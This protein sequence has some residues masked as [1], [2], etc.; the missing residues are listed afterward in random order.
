MAV[1]ST[2]VLIIG[3][4]AAGLSTANSVLA[5]YPEKEVTVVRNV[6]YT[7]VPCGIPYIYGMLNLVEKDKIPDEGFAK[8]G[9]NFVIGN[10]IDINR[11]AKLAIF[12]D[13]N[14]IK[15][16]KL[17][18][19]VGSKPSLPPIDGLDLKNV[20]PVI[21]D[22]EY[23][24]QILQSLDNIKDVV[25]IGGGFIGVEMAEQFMLKGD[26]NVTVLEAMPHCLQAACEEEAGIKVEEELTKMGIKVLNNSLASAV[27]GSDK[28]EGVKLA[29]GE[30]LKA[31]MVI[32]GIGAN[33]DT[34]LAEKTGLKF[35][36]T[37]GIIVDEFMRTSD[38]NVFA[39]GDCCIKYSSIT[40][41]PEGIRLASVAA[42]E[43]MIAGSNLYNLNRK[44][45]GAVG[46][47]AT[48]V[49]SV[50]V[51]S[52]GF[53]EKMCIDKNIAYYT[54]EITSPDRHP[55]SLPGCTPQTKVKVIFEQRTDKLIGGHVIG[56]TQAADMVNI[57]SL[58]IQIGVTVDE[59]ATS[60]YATHPL[61]TASPLVY[62][63]MWAAEKAVINKKSVII[64]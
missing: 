51:A 17:V 38:E 27:V 12:S 52:A 53:T 13:G 22:P 50:S 62:Q 20:F 36:K 35:D 47:F 14:E 21:K 58:G 25:V 61:L 43:G 11:E 28:A 16:E 8:K 29:S 23:L 1:K 2:D 54:G 41:E 3:G 55:G 60:Q 64:K 44:C 19:G 18:I 45:K 24:T 15:Y 42:S 37:M 4:S 7:V 10:V 26:Y 32:L 57:L 59:L 40:G 31:D 39:C 56:G 5:W 49:G 63:V 30:V 33:P 34:S 46:A 9:V 6:S 48:S